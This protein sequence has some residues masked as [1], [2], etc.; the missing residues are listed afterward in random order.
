MGWKRKKSLTTELPPS[1]SITG[2]SLS[3]MLTGIVSIT[4]II[5]QQAGMLKPLS[6]INIWISSF[7]PFGAW[8]LFFCIRLWLWGKNIDEHNFHLKE[9]ERAQKEW[10]AWAERYLAVVESCVFLPDTF[11]VSCL[12]NELPVSSGLTK[13][14]NYLAENNIMHN[15]IEV[16]LRGTEESL[17]GL[18][19]DLSLRVTLVTDMPAEESKA[20]FF[21]VWAILFPQL[22]APSVNVHTTAFSMNW[23]DERLKQPE[24]SVDLILVMQLK[25]SDEDTCSDGLAGLLLTSDDVAQKYQL[26]HRARLMRPMQIDMNNFQDDITLYLE[27]QTVGCHTSRVLSDS[28]CWATM[29]P[30]LMKIGR[31]HGT[32]WKP[33]GNMVLEQWS[34]IPGPA[35]PWLLTAIAADLIS[36]HDLSLLTLF[37]SGE[38]RFISTV[39]SGS[40][41]EHIG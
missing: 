37:S 10:K 13:K 26:P 6:G 28:C 17:S 30:L 3:G 9:A 31:E 1:L 16:L 27:T 19:S 4:L 29:T 21:S 33:A 11:T 32:S 35:A 40:E 38:E 20:T 18:S 34:G 7:V 24:L 8:I 22:S 15:A 12:H 5:V 39:T 14:I 41:D 36:L 25:G 23:A 2:W